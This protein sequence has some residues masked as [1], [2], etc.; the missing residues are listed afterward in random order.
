MN[1]NFDSGDI[2]D[3]L[4]LERSAHDTQLNS[5]HF[6]IRHWCKLMRGPIDGSEKCMP[7]RDIGLRG[8]ISQRRTLR[9]A[10]MIYDIKCSLWAGSERSSNNSNTGVIRM[11]SE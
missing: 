10:S 9:L 7:T 2:F 1:H 5:I 11:R 4:H 6:G 3:L 8:E